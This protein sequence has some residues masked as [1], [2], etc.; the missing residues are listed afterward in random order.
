MHNSI[1]KNML[2]IF[3]AACVAC[4]ALALC[5]CSSNADQKKDDAQLNRE[6]MSSVNRISAEAAE[7]LAGFGEAAAEDDLAAMRLAAA[8]A[9]KTLEKISELDAPKALAEVHSEYQDGAE[10]LSTALTDYIAVYADVQNGEATNAEL[11]AA[12]ADIEA[13]YASGIEHLSKADSMVAKL[14]GPTE[15]SEDSGENQSALGKLLGAKA[16]GESSDQASEDQ[17]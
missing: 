17:K 6:Y 8:D 1:K 3:A 4:L 13:L 7:S 12:L 16:A 2:R 9:A 15:G 14:A 10:A 5:S 11:E